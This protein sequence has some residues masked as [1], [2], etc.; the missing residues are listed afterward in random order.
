MASP[1]A[2]GLFTRAIGESGGSFGPMRSLT[3]AE[4]QGQQFVV[5]VGATPDVLKT[6]RAKSSD[7][8]IKATTDDDIDVNID[9]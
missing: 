7:E 1:L 9:G 6:L 4:K 3:G 2:A 5:K 8:L